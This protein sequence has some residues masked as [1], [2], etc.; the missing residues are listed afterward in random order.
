[1]FD[2]A[3]KIAFVCLL[4][5]QWSGC[6]T[7]RAFIKYDSFTGD[8]VTVNPGSVSGTAVGPVKGDSG[9]AVWADCTAKATESVYEM[10]AEAKAQGANAIGDIKWAAMG[11]STPSCKKGWG[12]VVLWPFLLTPLFMSTAV[13]ATAYK[14]DGSTPAA[15][16]APA[17]K[18]K[19]G[20]YMIPDSKE[21]QAKLAE[22]ITSDMM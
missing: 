4:A 18:K 20:F 5:L 3:L 11:D 6:S 13:S 22:E 2:K 8:G 17:K 19:S 21:A 15:P 14:V 10:I 16:A 1:M 12:Y 7:S 9:G